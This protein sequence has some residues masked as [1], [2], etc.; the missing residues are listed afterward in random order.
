MVLLPLFVPLRVECVRLGRGDL[1]H[2]CCV[3]A[4]RASCARVWCFGW[5]LG[6]LRGV[7]TVWVKEGER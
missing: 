3:V 6:I 5:V 1:P 7:G 4:L 2:G